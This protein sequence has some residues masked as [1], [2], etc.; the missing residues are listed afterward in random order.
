MKCCGTCQRHQ[1]NPNAAPIHPW[2]KPSGPWQRVHIDHAGPVDG[3]TYLIAVVTQNGLRLRWSR[4]QMLP[5][6][7]KF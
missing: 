2:E 6:L 3:K 5:I 7:L 1:G 4:V